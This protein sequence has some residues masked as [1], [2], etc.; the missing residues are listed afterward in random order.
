[1]SVFVKLLLLIILNKIFWTIEIKYGNYN[2]L[3]A[4]AG[5]YATYQQSAITDNIKLKR[6][7][8]T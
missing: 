8:Q 5:A 4:L 3:P 7:T 6:V 1:M 2:Y